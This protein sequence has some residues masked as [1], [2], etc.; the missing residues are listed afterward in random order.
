MAFEE[1][2]SPSTIYNTLVQLLPLRFNLTCIEFLWTVDPELDN[3]FLWY[4]DEYIDQNT[5]GPLLEFR[6]LETFRT[7]IFASFERIDDHFIKRIA[8]SCPN[9][10]IFDLTA[11]ALKPKSKVTLQGLIS[12]ATLC[13]RLEFI[14]MYFSTK[15]V[16]DLSLETIPGN[17]STTH[18]GV[19][20]SPI[21]TRDVR[22]LAELMKILFPKLEEIIY[23]DNM[24]EDNSSDEDE[25]SVLDDGQVMT[26]G[27][28]PNANFGRWMLVMDLIK[29]PGNHHVIFT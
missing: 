9:L 18:V 20:N 11:T 2:M 19:G 3:G 26:G 8:S 14:G 15:G 7:N 4:N 17:I 25:E 28:S 13:G 5:V 27:V 10:K 22:G 29:G 6:N 16:K 21:S 12:L 23:E 1:C 24:Y